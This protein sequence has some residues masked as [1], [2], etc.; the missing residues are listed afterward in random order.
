MSNILYGMSDGKLPF[1]LSDSLPGKV[2]P[3]STPNVDMDASDGPHTGIL[4]ASRDPAKDHY[5]YHCSQKTSVSTT[6]KES[7]SKATQTE[8]TKPEKPSIR[9]GI[10]TGWLSSS[11]ASHDS[12]TGDWWLAELGACLVSAMAMTALIIVIGH[13]NGKPL[14]K[15]PLH[16]TIA[17]FIAICSTITKATLLVPVVCAFRSLSFPILRGLLD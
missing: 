17:T 1:S 10:L 15:W 16:M 12:V 11:R 6:G 4:Q 2:A 5:D 8:T 14:P 7:E 9:R 13:H 3:P